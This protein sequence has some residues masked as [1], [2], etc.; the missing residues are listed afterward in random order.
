MKDFLFFIILLFSSLQLF[1]EEIPDKL[2]SGLVADDFAERGDAEDALYEWGRIT[3]QAAL[4]SIAKAAKSSEEP[5]MRER[6]ISVLK[7]LSDED[8]MSE[9]SGYL[10]ISMNE[11]VFMVDEDQIAILVTSVVKGT[12]AEKAGLKAGDGILTLNGEAWEG[13]E[14]TKAL[15][16]RIMGMKPRDVAKM[17]IFRAGEKPFELKVVLGRRPTEDLGMATGRMGEF[18]ELSRK[19]YFKDWLKSRKLSIE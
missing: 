14:A 4:E 8:Y 7:R 19:K 6:S 5:E 16:E 11:G 15:H 17:M 12:P 18:D 13:V 9:G 2:V 3:G 10:G 1:A